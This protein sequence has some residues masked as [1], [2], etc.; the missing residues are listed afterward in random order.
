MLISNLK[1]RLKSAGWMAMTMALLAVGSCQKDDDV[2]KDAGAESLARP[3]VFEADVLALEDA[4]ATK[5][6][7]LTSPDVET[8]LSNI[9][10]AFYEGGVL[11]DTGYYTSSFSSMSKKL[12]AG[13]TYNIYAA[14]NMGDVRASFPER[15]TEVS[16]FSYSIP[17]YTAVNSTGIPMSGKKEGYVAGSDGNRNIPLTR[18]LAKVSVNITCTWENPRIGEVRIFNMN[19]TLKPFGTSVVASASDVLSFQDY[20]TATGVGTYSAVLYV[21]ENM[22]GT[23]AGIADSFHKTNDQGNA[24]V[25]GKAA[26][27]TYMQTKVSSTS[28]YSGDVYYRSY[29]GNNITT[30]FDIKRNTHYV[31]N[32]TYTE[33]GLQYNDWKHDTGDLSGTRYRYSLSPTSQELYVNQT[34]DWQVMR[35]TDTYAAGTWTPGTTPSALPG[36]DYSYTVADETVATA[37][38]ANADTQRTTA[39]KKG[40]TNINVTIAGNT[41]TLPVEVRDMITNELE[42]L[43]SPD[44]ASA[45]VGG[46]ISL[47]AKFY[48]LTNGVRDG[49]RDVTQDSGTAWSRTAGH[50][51]I[52]V[53]NVSPNKGKVTATSG[54]T[55]TI[56]A[57]YAGLT[58]S[59]EV[60]FG[61]VV[62]DRYRIVISPASS[63]IAWNATQA[64][65]VN[66]YTDRY[67]NGTRTVEGTT[68]VAMSAFDFDW[69]SSSA[70]VATVANGVA[71]GK[72]TGSATITATL[73][74]SVSEYSKYGNTT[75]SA[76]LNVSQVQTHRLVLTPDAASKPY[77]GTINLTARYYTTTNGVEDAGVVVTPSAVTKV[78]G[79]PNITLTAGNPSTAKLTNPALSVVADNK[80]SVKATYAGVE[81][82]AVDIE[83]TNVTTYANT[84]LVVTGPTSV[85][86]GSTTGNYTATLY[87]QTYVNGVASGS[88]ATRDVSTSA[89]F[90]SSNTGIATVT[91]RTAK[92]VAAGTAY[93]SAR[94]SDGNGEI[95]SADADRAQLTVG[96]VVTH[97]LALTPDAASKPYNGTINLTARYY[98][99]TNGVEDA[100][101]VVTPSAVT[102]V[103]GGSNITFAVGNPST[104]KL[105]NPALSV[106]ANNK[107]SVKATY[108]GID[109][110]AVDIEF[111]N[112]TTYAY[113]RLVV[114]GQSSVNVGVTTSDYTATLYTQTY[115]NGVASG[116][117][118]TSD[119]SASAS[120]S[121]SAT[122]IATMSGRKATGKAAGTTYISA[123]YSG[124]HGNASSANA[125]RAQLT[126]NNVVSHRLVLTADNASKNYNE[127]INLT[128]RYY[129]TTNGSE[130]G[131]VAVTPGT[132]VMSA[133]GSNITLTKGSPSTAKL[134]NQTLSV[135]ANNKGTVRATYQGET[136]DLAIEFKNVTTYGYTRLVVT[137]DSSVSVGGT[138]S[139]YRATL[140]TQTYVN[141]AASGSASTSD[142]S[143]S[144]SFSSSATTI[145]TMSGRKATGK[146]AGTTYI[147]A[148][149]SGTYG[150]I[151]SANADRAT[152]VVQNVEEDKYRIV[153]SPASSSIAWN[154]TQAYTVNRYTDHYV[155]G[156]QTST[157]STPTAMAASDFNW[158][159]SATSVATV[160]N[161]GVATGVSGGTATITAT[162]KSGVTGYDKYSPKSVSAT[163][164]VTDV[165]SISL[166]PASKT[167]TCGTDIILTPT[168]RKNGSV[169]TSGFTI[170]WSS[171]NTN[172][173]RVSG[174]N[175]SATVSSYNGGTATITATVNG[176]SATSSVTFNGT[177]RRY[178]ASPASVNMVEGG[179][180]SQMIRIHQVD[181]TYSNG[182]WEVDSDVVLKNTFGASPSYTPQVYSVVDNSGYLNHPINYRPTWNVDY[183]T[184]SSPSGNAGKSGFMTVTILS[185]G[186]TL[187]ISYTITGDSSEYYDYELELTANGSSTGASATIG[188]GITLKVLMKTYRRVGS[189]PRTLYST[190]NVTEYTSPYV[191]WYRAGTFNND[192]SP[193]T[194]PLYG[195]VATSSTVVTMSIEAYY[196]AERSNAVT[197]SFTDAPHTY[198]LEVLPSMAS[199]TVGGTQ[200]F[201]AYLVTDGVRA[202]TPLTSGVT[203]SS[204]A[205][206]TISSSG[207]ATGAS[208]GSATI[209]ARYAHSSGTL[210]DTSTLTVTQQDTYSLVVKPV[211]P[212][213]QVG[214]TQQFQAYLVVNGVESSSPLTSGV[215]WSSGST[216]VATIS[217]SGLATGK[218]VGS[219][220]ITAR[221]T[222][223]GSSQVSGSTTLTVTAAPVTNTYS[224]VVEFAQNPIGV[225]SAN[226]TV[227]SAYLVTDGDLSTKTLITDASKITWTS[228]TT[229]VATA[230]KISSGSNAGKATITGVA[231][232]TSKITAQYSDGSI[233][234][235]GDNTIT[236]NSGGVEIDGGWDSD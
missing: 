110:P 88:P 221:Y 68:P 2:S 220:V 233:S 157:G 116:S 112:V 8:K 182:S 236:V 48:T 217:G 158:S 78:S 104:A 121:S 77:N 31:W 59:K 130:D 124:P 72:G 123:S 133:G 144:A 213:V 167:E 92:G 86:V 152:L 37:A 30:N 139:D 186:E 106:V 113:T 170:N 235:T 10:L 96:N 13:K 183:F 20:E 64:Y 228:Q 67:T 100:G 184:V 21:P 101:V 229:S 33:D 34:G 126:V 150:N 79:G 197:L 223:S 90:S 200:Q 28:T 138:T 132:L 44:P 84:R 226:A 85:N 180:D 234:A 87:T 145:A 65:T 56:Q 169:V 120:F 27:L 225:G 128:A 76:T 12:L 166:S 7:L 174:T 66:R 109:S 137:G 146:A 178:Y 219:S 9:V 24:S 173:A 232:G 58:A 159:S 43:S 119:V 131:G 231:A 177:R 216:S 15:E 161:G 39:H 17:S 50:T 188:N 32:L 23:I 60:T 29:L 189:G 14:A 11:Y 69:T 134:T 163:L 204:T 25:S 141:G 6:S 214:N 1:M 22:Q 218:A 35:Y 171:S 73:K 26:L 206:A 215:T 172:I 208:V 118:V 143:A 54:G 151:A 179:Y 198:G 154:A 210:T 196:N 148:S 71:T 5:S 181:E 125:D 3:E 149:Y 89:T 207:L 16:G 205:A 156:M 38:A 41:L 117:P 4:F 155:N 164:T 42:I 168:V 209:T 222:P 108:A 82:P 93:I 98:T 47:T 199:V 194:I 36:T 61:D 140:Y 212:S 18:L 91:G 105:T 129:T 162:L 122:A 45:S 142:V 175:S 75:V 94:F 115:V 153:I 187:D 135:V 176:A 111:T 136:A 95:T 83:F 192:L 53:N 99:T 62:E 160:S 190:E 193:I 102:K 103:S 107:A 201:Q 70:A 19:K 51:G 147:A 114:N 46:T 49:G 63:S 81:S 55:A 80:A 57:A 185:D 230:A 211:N 191:R 195:S 74:S 97:R 227:A 202:S 52:S 40:S 203:W 224:I 127:T 165:W